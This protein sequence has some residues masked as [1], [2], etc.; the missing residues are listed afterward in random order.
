MLCPPSAEGLSDFV[1]QAFREWQHPSALDQWTNNQFIGQQAGNCNSFIV[2]Y[3][4]ADLFAMHHGPRSI[5]LCIQHHI[6]L[7]SLS[8]QVSRPSH[9]WD[10]AI[11]IFYIKK[12]KVKLMVEV[13]VENHNMCP[14]FYQLTSLWFQVNQPSHSWGTSFSKFDLENPRSM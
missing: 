3:Y 4:L 13:N 8:F 6:Q 11:S 1:I 12:S 10:I 5:P 14:T 2:T 9:S 7:T